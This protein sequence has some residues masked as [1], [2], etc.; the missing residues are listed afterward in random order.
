[1][2]PPGA[3]NRQAEDWAPPECVF[4]WLDE[5]EERATCSECERVDG[6]LVC[7]RCGRVFE[8][9]RE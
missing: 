1:M 8:D 9:G 4:V 3:S 5:L 2:I 6:Q 7:Q